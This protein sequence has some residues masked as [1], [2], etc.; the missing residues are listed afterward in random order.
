L[1]TNAGY[2]VVW[3]V[4]AIH[5]LM[6]IEVLQPKLVIIDTPLS[7]IEDC[8]LIEELRSNDSTS[9]LKILVLMSPELLPE[10]LTNF[11][12]A[13]ADDYLLKPINPE[14]FINK[15]KAFFAS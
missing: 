5:A 8:E 1:L 11:W 12:E 14:F 15:I 4:D 13:G 3:L 6:N 9:L 2:Q 10:D 7:D